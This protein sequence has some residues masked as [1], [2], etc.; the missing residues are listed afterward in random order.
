MASMR[1]PR[2]EQML[3]PG[4]PSHVL[5]ST[6]SS[7]SCAKK[8]K[9]TADRGAHRAAGVRHPTS[10]RPSFRPSLA[11]GPNNKSPV[12]AG[13]FPMARGGFEPP[14]PAF[15]VR[16]STMLSYLAALLSSQPSH[17]QGYG[18]TC[19]CQASRGRWSRR[20]HDRDAEGKKAPRHQGIEASR[21]RGIEVSRWRRIDWDRSQK[22]AVEVA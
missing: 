2:R 12:K 8:S 18:T 13:F 5:T 15:S 16:C 6:L 20:I 22:L 3:L 7:R 4:R 10:T 11:E 19:G 9:A 17:A 1:P 14:T 21:H